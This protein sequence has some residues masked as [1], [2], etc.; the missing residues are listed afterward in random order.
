MSR[1]EDPEAAEAVG[2]TDPGTGDEVAAAAGV[3]PL[4][5]PAQV[6]DHQVTVDAVQ[7]DGNAAVAAANEFDEA[8]TGST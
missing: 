6:G 8:P 1:D 5:V 3:L 4:G 2:L 7:L